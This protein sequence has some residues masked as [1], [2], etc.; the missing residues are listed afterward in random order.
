M[1]LLQKSTYRSPFWLPDGHFQTI[2]PSFFRQSLPVQYHRER[3]LTQDGDFLDLDWSCVKTNHAESVNKLV[4]LS[5]GLEGSSQSQYIRGMVQHLNQAGYDCLA[6]NFR[7]CSGEM[8][9]RLRFYHSG[10]TEDLQDVI[11]CALDKQYT[12][13]HLMG[14]SLGGNLTLKYLGE[15]GR[16]LPAEIQHSIVYSVPLDL[17]ACSLA[18][19]KGANQVYMHR[20]LKSLKPKIIQK[21]IQFPDQIDLNRFMEVKTLYDFDD[22]YTAGLHGFDHADHYYATCSS[23]HFIANITIPTLIVNAINDP[24]VPYKSLPL[25]EIADLKFVF[26]ENPKEGGHCGFRPILLKNNVY[27]SEERALSFLNTDFSYL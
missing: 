23:G 7:S 26:L 12:H 4:I 14:F 24:I 27:W 22:I 8:N 10:A 6:W 5:H 17:R 16:A 21:S 18:M 2:Y 9:M 1:P 25:D 3:I 20:F 11:Q 13:I 19:T 15:Q